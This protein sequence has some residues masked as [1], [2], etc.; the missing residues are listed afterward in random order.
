MK[1][2]E[3]TIDGISPIL[4][5]RFKEQ[6]E[7]PIKMKK[8]G[9]TNYGTP[10]EQAEKAAYLDSSG[11]A[12]I[13]STWVKGAIANVSSDYKLPASR[14]SVKSVIGGAV[15]PIEEKCYFLQK[16][17][18][19][20]I[21]IDSRPCVVQRFRIMRHRARFEKWTVKVALEIE[22]SILDPDNV[23]EMLCDAGR[24]SGIGD[25]RPSKGGPYGKFKVVQ[26]KQL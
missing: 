7:V 1:T 10:R 9:K 5:N 25:F 3:V 17:T 15:V 24:R 13:P 6:S 11:K 19:K 2:F 26:W 20:N 16:Y 8:A 18:K 21:E 22:D 14:K 4:V 23:H 12:W